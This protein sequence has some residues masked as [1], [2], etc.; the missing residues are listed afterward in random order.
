MG[1]QRLVVRLLGANAGKFGAR[2]QQRRLQCLNV[3]RQLLGTVTHAPMES[4]KPRFGA[5]F[6]Q[7][8]G[9]IR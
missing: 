2:C 1:D 6:L 9:I 8:H 3:F 4:Q 7:S 5:G